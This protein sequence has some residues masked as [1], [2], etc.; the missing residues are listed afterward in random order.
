M[1]SYPVST[2]A[3]LIINEIEGPWP[4]LV[5]CSKFKTI[6]QLVGCNVLDWIISN[7][8]W[9]LNEGH[10]FLPQ[11]VTNKKV[12]NPDTDNFFWQKSFMHFIIEMTWPRISQK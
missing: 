6:D 5:S 4:R 3:A 2:T 12:K 9:G 1:N 8:Y 10:Y 7:V 11:N